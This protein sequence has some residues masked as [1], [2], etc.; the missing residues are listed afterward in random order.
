MGMGR[1]KVW[2]NPGVYWLATCLCIGRP[3]SQFSVEG[4]IVIVTGGSRG[5]GLQVVTG[6]AEAGADVT[7]IYKTSTDTKETAERISSKTG[8]R[9]SAYQCD[10][11]DRQGLERTQINS[12]N[13]DGVMWTALAAGKIFKSQER[14]NLVITA[15]V[16]A[17]LV[18]VPQTQAAY[19]LSNA[20]VLQLA[21]M[22]IRQPK[23]LLEKW[24]GMIRVGRVYG[25]LA[26]DASCFMTGSNVIIDGGFARVH[27]HQH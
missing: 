26:S 19:N 21:K 16:S 20:G 11:T 18:S 27:N 10:V 25:F 5:I 12:V 4:K 22:M 17:G 24:F 2:G 8:A 13:F 1:V 7:F 23:E 3:I 9:A 6:L 14:E 15:S